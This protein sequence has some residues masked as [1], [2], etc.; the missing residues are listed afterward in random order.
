M[1]PHAICYLTIYI[2][3]EAA[4]LRR[5]GRDRRLSFALLG[6]AF[7]YSYSGGGVEHLHPIHDNLRVVIFYSSVE[8]GLR[9]VIV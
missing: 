6:F 9:A 1:P 8:S 4:R 7:N 5:H 2:A 3:R